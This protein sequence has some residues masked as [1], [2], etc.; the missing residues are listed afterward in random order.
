MGAKKITESL[1]CLPLS[2]GITRDFFETLKKR[3]IIWRHIIEATSL[4]LVTRYVANGDGIG[5]N[6]LVHP[7]AKSR[8]VRLLPLEDFAPV[9]MGAL[10]RGEPTP[11]MQAAIDSVR[12]YANAT[13]P[14]WACAD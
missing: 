7:K 14:N 13:W 11:L 8:E 4:D 10:W 2:T 6:V 12:A 1:I 3:G 9:T 5:L